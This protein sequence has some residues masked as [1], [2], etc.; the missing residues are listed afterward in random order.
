MRYAFVIV[1]LTLIT[2]GLILVRRQ[3]MVVSHQARVLEDRRPALEREL[4]KERHRY[5]VHVRLD[6][7][8]DQAE[9]LGL[10]FIDRRGPDG[11]FARR[12]RRERRAPYGLDGG[13]GGRP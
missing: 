1:S 8:P 4:R 5:A 10:N 13:P 3:E 6:E 12:E 7:I 2:V 9:R 11:A